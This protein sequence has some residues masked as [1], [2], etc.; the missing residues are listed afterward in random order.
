MVFLRLKEIERDWRLREPNPLVLCPFKD[1]F[2]HRVCFEPA[3]IMGQRC[4]HGFER[5]SLFLNWWNECGPHSESCLRFVIEGPGETKSQHSPIWSI[6]SIIHH[7]KKQN[8]WIMTLGPL[9]S[10]IIFHV[11]QCI[12]SLKH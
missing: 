5:W 11:S 2:H 3:Q 12:M 1:Y 8:I 7:N 9:K 10:S 6:Y 4:E